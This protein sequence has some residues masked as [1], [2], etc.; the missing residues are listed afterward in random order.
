[1]VTESY[2]PY[3]LDIILIDLGL[4]AGGE[5][6]KRRPCLVLSKRELDKTTKRALIC[7]ITSSSP[8][9]YLHIPLPK[10]QKHCSGTLVLDQLKSFDY[11]FRNAKT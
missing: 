7:P 5:M 4:Q 8:A 11:R 9:G 10:N 1:M 2:I 6:E 3:Q